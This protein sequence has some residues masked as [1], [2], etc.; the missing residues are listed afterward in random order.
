VNKLD[1][2]R[3]TPLHIIMDVFSRDVKVAEE[4]TRILVLNGAKLNELDSE[5]L[6]PLHK[7]VIKKHVEG[8][9]LIIKLNKELKQQESELFNLNLQGGEKR[10]PPIFYALEKKET[11]T[12]ELLFLNGASV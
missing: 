5:K 12:A 6:S 8:V 7:A 9:K 3:Q 2:K 4:I 1:F 11:A 10:F